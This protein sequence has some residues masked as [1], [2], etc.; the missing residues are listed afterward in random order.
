M[1]FCRQHSRAWMSRTFY[2]LAARHIIRCQRLPKAGR[3]CCVSPLFYSDTSGLT[4][5]ESF[6]SAS[7]LKLR[8]DVCSRGCFFPKGYLAGCARRRHALS[9]T[10]VLDPR[11]RFP[12]FCAADGL[13]LDRRQ[14]R[15]GHHFICGRPCDARQVLRRRHRYGDR[16]ERRAAYRSRAAAR[17]DLGEHR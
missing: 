7:G 10:S 11:G 9:D 6:K 12:I 1:V 17:R 2:M 14:K 3:A 8:M 13:D 16:G 15:L 4:A 5:H